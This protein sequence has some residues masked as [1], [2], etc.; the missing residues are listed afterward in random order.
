M[1]CHTERPRGRFPARLVLAA[2]L[3]LSATLAP[4]VSGGGTAAADASSTAIVAALGGGP[5]VTGADLVGDAR[6]VAVSG[7]GIAGFPVQ[8]PAHLVLS[9]GPAEA[10]PGQPG[11]F[12]SI[13][14]QN[15][16]AGADGN[17]LSQVLVHTRP[18]AGA[19][20]VA[21]DFAFVSEEFPEYV[22]TEYN[23]I[24]T[25]EL[26][27]SSFG[28]QDDQVVAPHNFA[29]DTKG[30]PV[31]VNTVFGMSP[32]P[33]TTM[34]GATPA[35][36][37]SS[38]VRRKPDGTMDL[39]LSVQDIGDSILDS[40]VVVDNLRF[41]NGPTCAAGSASL[42]DADG[43]ALPDTWE[44]AGVDVDRDGTIDLDLPAMG[45]RPDHKDL[46]V[47]IDHMVRAPTCAWLI[48]W[49][50]RDFAPRPS[51]LDDVRA[52]FAAAPVANPDG[53]PGIRA[54][55]DAGPGSVM[56][57][58]TTWGARSRAGV[59]P[60]TQR[61]GTFTASGDYDWTAFDALKDAHLDLARRGVFHYAVYGDTYGGSDASGIS[62]GTPASD[63]LVTDG[64]PGWGGG[65][66]RT[67][68]RGTLLHELGHGLGLRHGGDVHTNPRP[69]YA[70][71]MSYAFQLVGLPPDSRLDLSRGAPFTDWTHLAFDGGAIGG[72]GAT[73][74]LPA[75]TE[76]DEPSLA[77][78]K[79]GQ[80]F[81]RPGDGHARFAGPPVLV[82]GSG[83]GHLLLDVVNSGP[84]AD[85][86]RVT[87]STPV[88]AVGGEAT[89]TVPPGATRRVVLDVDT[90]GLAPAT[91]P[92]TV[93]LAG[94]RAGA[95]P[96]GDRGEVRVVPGDAATRQA[97]ASALA[98]VAALAPGTGPDPQVVQG[99]RAAL[100]NVGGGAPVPSP[101]PSPSVTPSPSAPPSPTPS[102]T[103][104]P[105][106][107][108]GTATCNGLVATIVGHGEA[109]I[110]G[111][112]GDDV[113]VGTGGGET[114]RG[115]GGDDTI[116]GLGGDDRLVGEDGRD[117]LIGG[118]GDDTLDGGD[119]DD[120]LRAG[121]GADVLRGDDGK[122]L[123]HGGGGSDV[124]RGGSG[125]DE[126]HGDADPDVLWGGDANDR[127]FGEEGT[128][129]LHGNDGN[130]ALFGGPDT[131]TLDGGPGRN[132]LVE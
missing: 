115:R 36:T 39:I 76:A 126:V 34:D 61:L 51:A 88:A 62:R 66:T 18:P 48:C 50:G 26:N 77:Q 81:A 75:T 92:V 85:A 25:A 105:S 78:L 113:I 53:T 114:I 1:K 93:S 127:L 109:V 54:H 90:A 132:Q 16:A 119:N 82:A 8:G 89:V 52:A 79:S 72:R 23:D 10:V 14:L 67:Q 101:S 87:A 32:V 107:P 69:G 99:L 95:G 47:E 111:T 74:M 118:D 130:D 120:V 84:V 57:G 24:F 35:L 60:W 29:Y 65:F 108:P 22:G 73:A 30:N 42:A 40:A 106:V 100:A 43:D 5:A 45:A 124:V 56:T 20:C 11:G 33:G 123:L 116:C 96:A 117:T 3:A 83:T 122:D 125:R 4:A 12:T 31:S 103:P 121:A 70:S 41:G 112:T 13:D 59:L 68:E 44:T 63:L 97:L 71:V 98:D 128:D 80:A 37:A 19:T 110:R 28:V 104:A 131:D 49:G 102:V 64:A 55:L 91:L 129:A 9:N 27:E 17:D 46:F 38:P 58:T 86:F 2:T 6:A 7:A 21:F 94:T 15:A